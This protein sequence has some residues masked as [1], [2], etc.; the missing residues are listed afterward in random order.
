LA[1]SLHGHGELKKSQ[2]KSVVGGRQGQVQISIDYIGYR[3]VVF[4]FSA[5]CPLPLDTYIHTYIYIHT[6]T[7]TQYLHSTQGP[8]RDQTTPIVRSGRL[9]LFIDQIEHPRH[10]P[11]TTGSHMDIGG[12]NAAPSTCLCGPGAPGRGS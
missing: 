7:H 1:V 3:H 8:Y 11:S 9:L 10:P 12:S 5:P 6:H 4:F 2:N